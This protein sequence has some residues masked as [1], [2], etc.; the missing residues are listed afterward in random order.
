MEDPKAHIKAAVFDLGKVLVDFDYAIAIR[1][2]A[3]RGRMSAED[4]AG[5]MMTA[6]LLL[7]YERGKF[8]TQEFFARVCRQTGY[9]GTL[10]EFAGH[11]GDIFS[12]IEPMVELHRD[13]RRRGLPTFIFSNT[14]EL[15]IRHI[16]KNFPFFSEFTGYFLSYEHHCMKPAPEFYEVLERRSGFCGEE[17]FYLDD[18]PEN[19]QAAIAR[20]WRALVHETPGQT[21]CHLRALGLL[22]RAE[23]HRPG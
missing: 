2:I 12:P 21:I 18:R 5:M 4:L 7:D 11:F 15:A 23:R 9:N 17:I 20:G 14:N 16:R 8:S 19:V 3:A 22:D 10:E 1:K 13:L 6:P